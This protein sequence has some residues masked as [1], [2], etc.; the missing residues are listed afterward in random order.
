M[1]IAFRFHFSQLCLGIGINTGCYGH[2]HFSITFL[3]WTVELI[4]G[5]HIVPED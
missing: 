3:F 4:L 2:V 5:K 1:A